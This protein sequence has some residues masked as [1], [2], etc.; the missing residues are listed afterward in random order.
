[1]PASDTGAIEM[2][3]WSLLGE[4][5]GRRARL[6]ELRPGVGR[7]TRPSSSSSTRACSR[8]R[9]ARC[10][11]SRAVDFARDVIFPW[12]G[13]TSGV[14]VPNA[15]LDPA[16]ARGPH[17]LR[18]DLGGV[19]DGGRRSPSSTSSPGPGRRCSAARP[20]TACSRSRRARSRGSSRY[21]PAAAAAED[22]PP[23]EEGQ[24]RRARSSRARP[25]TRRR[26]CASR[27]RSTGSPGP[28]ASAACRR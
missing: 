17:A 11:I 5:A 21:T 1:M 18:R 10:P 14:R 4:R 15:R 22:L 7:P 27:T 25:S 16:R 24:A 8:R 9:T 12:N 13:T 3:M 19:R 2:A 20:R 23:D 26:C 28:S 6:G